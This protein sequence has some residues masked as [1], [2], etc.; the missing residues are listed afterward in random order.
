MLNLTPL[1]AFADEP[2]LVLGLHE[3]GSYAFRLL[4]DGR[5]FAA[6]TDEH[7]PWPQ[8]A[9]PFAVPIP[10]GTRQLEIVWEAQP[11]TLSLIQLLAAT[12]G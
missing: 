8:Q 11:A 9:R 2:L 10:V 5:P 3:A 7:W 1:G 4:A 12:V 6:F